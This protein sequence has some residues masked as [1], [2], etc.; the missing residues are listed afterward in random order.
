[1]NRQD[2]C[3]TRMQVNTIQCYM[4]YFQHRTKITLPKKPLYPQWDDW[5]GGGQKNNL[6]VVHPQPLSMCKIK[7]DA[8]SKVE[9]IWMHLIELSITN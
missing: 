4:V 1:M 7:Q 5:K 8:R 2:S 3:L 6:I 9:S